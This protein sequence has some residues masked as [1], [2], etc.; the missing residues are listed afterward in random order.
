MALHRGKIMNLCFELEGRSTGH[1]LGLMG[2]GL[3]L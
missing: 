3:R 2:I 1:R